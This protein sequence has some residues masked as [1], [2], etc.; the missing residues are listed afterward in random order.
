MAVDPFL[1]DWGRVRPDYPRSAIEGRFVGVMR[2][3]VEDR[4]FEL[5]PQGSRCIRRWDVHELIVTDE[6]AAPSKRV[7]R[8]AYL[9]FVEFA[10][11]GVVLQGDEVRIGDALIGHVAGFDETHLPN[12]LNIVLKGSAF[13]SGVERG[14]SLGDLITVF[15]IFSA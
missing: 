13:A 12:H 7:G 11:G 10:S 6:A 3:K 2:L 4:G 15:P 8:C 5:I 1:T 9:G 14:F